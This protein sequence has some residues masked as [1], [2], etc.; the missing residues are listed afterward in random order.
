MKIDI[1]PDEMLL[2]KEYKYEGF[3]LYRTTASLLFLTKELKSCVF[4]KASITP[5]VS[6]NIVIGCVTDL[7]MEGS[8]LT[9]YLTIE[10][11]TP[12]RLEIQNGEK[13]W[14]EG[15]FKII[16]TDIV[17]DEVL[18]RKFLL[19]SVKISRTCLDSNLPEIGK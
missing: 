6:G 5:I 18:P 16:D 8:F 10:S 9:A 3:N 13:L 17:E 7:F 14:A 12:E 1:N 2:S 11:A 4:E 15:I 19:T